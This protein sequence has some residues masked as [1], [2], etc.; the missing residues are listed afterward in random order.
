VDFLKFIVE[1]TTALAWPGAVV[2]AVYWLRAPIIDLLPYLDELKY[3]DFGLKFRR[4]I[5]KAK[6]EVTPEDQVGEKTPQ[7]LEEENAL[8]RVAEVSPRAA[9]LESWMSLQD[10]LL[11]ISLKKGQIDNKENYREHSRVGHA[12][13]GIKAFTKSDFDAYHKL[14]DLRNK[15]AHAPDFALN[16]QDA[17]EYVGL[18]MQLVS[19]AKQRVN[20]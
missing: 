8:I 9:I 7:I 1:M 13:L 3:K 6:E 12:M 14:R 4:D 15:A 19:M 17:K 16:T 5:N 20:T 10:G 18:A 2:L 11:D